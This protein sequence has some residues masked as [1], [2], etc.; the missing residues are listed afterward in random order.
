MPPVLMDNDSVWFSATV[1]PMPQLTIDNR[2][3]LN[4]YRDRVTHGSAFNN[5]IMR[6]KWNYQFT[7]QLSL[8]TVRAVQRGALQPQLL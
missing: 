1:K 8:R 3:I 5:H 4:R 6:S 2:Y 7:K